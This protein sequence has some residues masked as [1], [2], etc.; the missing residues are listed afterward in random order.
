MDVLMYALFLLN[1]RLEIRNK[2]LKTKITL[3]TNCSGLL[4]AALLVNNEIGYVG[5]RQY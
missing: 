2:K 5:M 1:C 4:K 3:F